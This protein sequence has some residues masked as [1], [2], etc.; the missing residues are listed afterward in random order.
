M[1]LAS[2]PGCPPSPVFYSM[3]IWRERPGKSGCVVTSGGPVPDEGSR[4]PF[5]RPERSQGSTIPI[6]LLFMTLGT[7]R[8]EVGIITPYPL[9]TCRLPHVTRC[10]RCSPSLFAYCKPSKTGGG[11][12]AIVVPL[13]LQPR[14]WHHYNNSVVCY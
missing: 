8:C 3:Q 4:S 14:V 2:F 11:N 6:D 9:S 12:K 13:V 1:V 7:D 10:L 5:W